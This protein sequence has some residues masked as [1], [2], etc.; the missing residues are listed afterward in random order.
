MRIT[1]RS[2]I[3]WLGL[4]MACFLTVSALT[5]TAPENG[6]WQILSIVYDAPITV[7]IIAYDSPTTNLRLRYSA[8]SSRNH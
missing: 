6:V 7:A 5:P 3:L 8:D 2:I 4:A 1:A